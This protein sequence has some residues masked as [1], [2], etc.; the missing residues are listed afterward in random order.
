MLNVG[1][2]NLLV[3]LKRFAV[4]KRET[5][6]LALD[7]EKTQNKDKLLYYLRPLVKNGYISRRSDGLYGLL[8]KGAELV[9]HIKPVLTVGGDEA[10]RRRV[11]EVSHM[12]ALMAWHGIPTVTTIP[13]NGQNGFVP[14]AIW[15][16]LR[17]GIISTTRFLGVLFYKN[18]APYEGIR[19][20][21][22]S[23]GAIRR[24]GYIFEAT[25]DS[26]CTV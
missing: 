7:N 3:H 17:N 8:H 19:A 9:S 18:V 2:I 5:C 20:S 24:M 12:A 1:Q 6:L 10:G 23:T 25:G 13:H 14:S 4:A 16:T 15:R 11:A 21:S 26:T 22:T